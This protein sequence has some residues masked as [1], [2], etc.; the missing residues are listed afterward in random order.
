MKS[1]LPI[2]LIAASLLAIT[3]IVS[4]A[5]GA[6]LYETNCTKCHGPDGKGTTKMGIKAGAKDLT[7]PAIQAEMT[8]EKV[9]KQI[10]EGVKDGDK[11]KMKAFPD[12]SDDDVKALVAYTLATFKK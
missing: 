8:E 9:T 1:I 5:D 11:V 2:S 4:A 12:L 3:N 7:D 10:R 6:A